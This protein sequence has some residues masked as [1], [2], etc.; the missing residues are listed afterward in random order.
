VKI[1]GRS[2]VPGGKLKWQI[3]R[4]SGTGEKTPYLTGET[5]AGTDSAQSGLFT[6]SL[7]L[8][9]GTYELRV[10][11]ADKGSGQELNVDTRKFN[12]N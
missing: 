4:A 6:L 5:T 11:Q 8:T 1:T 2:T 9:S 12:V 10:S 3:L 7:N